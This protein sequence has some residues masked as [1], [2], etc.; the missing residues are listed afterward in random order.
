MA[1]NALRISLWDSHKA[2]K[3]LQVLVYR[4]WR[5]SYFCQDNELVA[6]WC[7]I[8]Y[9]VSWMMIKSSNAW[10]ALLRMFYT[11]AIELSPGNLGDLVELEE[12]SSPVQAPTQTLDWTM[13]V[14]TFSAATISFIIGRGRSHVNTTTALWNGYSVCIPTVYLGKLRI[15]TGGQSE[16][17]IPYNIW[18]L[19]C[20]LVLGSW[21]H[22]EHVFPTAGWWRTGAQ[23]ISLLN[24]ALTSPSLSTPL[25]GIV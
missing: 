21:I 22:T 11:S 7:L 23:D 5:N 6:A 16:H 25:L 3:F 9:W 4:I 10:C 12:Y 18:T 14:L 13:V 19:P 24:L 1:K 2:D 20:M 17:V 8:T 15:I